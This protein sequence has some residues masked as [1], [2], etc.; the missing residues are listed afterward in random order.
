[1]NEEALNERSARGEKLDRKLVQI[2]VRQITLQ[3]RGVWIDMCL[4]SMSNLMH[5][6]GFAPRAAHVQRRQEQD[7][8]A[9]AAFQVAVSS[10]LADPSFNPINLINLDETA[11]RIVGGRNMTWARMEYDTGQEYDMRQEYDMGQVLTACGSTAMGAPGT[12]SQCW[13]VARSMD[14]SS[15]SVLSRR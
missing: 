5:R 2:V 8:H 12:A 6:L 14:R 15:R 13:P 11:V 9:E 1:L 3:T 7:P 4:S 10:I